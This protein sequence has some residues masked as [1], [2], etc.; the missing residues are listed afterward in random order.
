MS[1]GTIAAAIIPDRFKDVQRSRVGSANNNPAEGLLDVRRP[2]RGIQIKED[3]YAT[4]K[5]IRGNGEEIPLVNA[6]SRMG[7]IG[8]D[9]R[10]AS[11]S[12]SNFLIQNVTEER[13]EKSQVVETFG[14]AFIFFYGQRPRVITIQGVFVNTFDFNWEAEWWHNYDNYLRGTRCVEQDARVFL[15]Y[16]DTMVSGYIMSSSSSKNS[17]ERNFVPFVFQLFVT[18]YTTISKVGNPN[19]D[20]RGIPPVDDASRWMFRP[21]VTAVGIPKQFTTIGGMPLPYRQG[22]SLSLITALAASA[23]NVVNSAFNSAAKIANLVT[24]PINYL[25]AFIGNTVRVP[26]GFEGAVVF[27]E[28]LVSLDLSPRSSGPIKYKP[29]FGYNWDE[30]VGGSYESYERQYASSDVSV[31][32]KLS[33][34]TS[35]ANIDRLS[36]NI[37]T[38][39]RAEWESRGLIPPQGI[40]TDLI[41]GVLGGLRQTPIGL[42]MLKAMRNAMVTPT[43]YASGAINLALAKATPIA[44]GANVAVSQIA[45]ADTMAGMINPLHSQGVDRAMNPGGPVTISTLNSISNTINRVSGTDINSFKSFVG[46]SWPSVVGGG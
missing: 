34:T 24:M 28:T 2:T 3:T 36:Q 19:P 27:D 26:Y 22:Q 41:S 38:R 23:V 46:S 13:V 14:E 8:P 29:E 17:V 33:Y 6:G 4:M 11:P 7:D 25:D 5:L 30:F 44:A 37:T 12:Y 39:A 9:G 21:D 18:D 42:Q 20:Q 40:V 43:A 35:A 10:M 45:L 31:G 15:T 16:D 1:T 32:A